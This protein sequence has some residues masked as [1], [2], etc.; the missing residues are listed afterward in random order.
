MVGTYPNIGLCL[1]LPG[2]SSGDSTP[3]MQE[4]VLSADA[5]AVG[6]EESAEDNANDQPEAPTLALQSLFS[7]IRG[8]V[9]QLDSR[10]LPLCLHQVLAKPFLFLKSWGHC[11]P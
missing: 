4:D 2:L 1:L 11:Q 6:E 5:R 8:E 3:L 9:E 10:A 7:L